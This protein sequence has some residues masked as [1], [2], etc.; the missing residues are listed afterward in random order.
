M[1]NKSFTLRPWQM[2]DLDSLVKYADNPAIARNLTDAF[3]SPY[4]RE[5]GKKYMEMVCSQSFE[6]IFAIDMDGE[7][8]GSIGVFPQNDIHRLN[9]EMGYWL[10]EPFWGNGIMPEAVTQIVEYAFKTLDISR[11]Y[12]RPFGRNHASQRVLE[13]AGFQLEARFEKVL[14]KNGVLEDELIYGFRKDNNAH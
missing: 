3:P 4:T 7:A 10:A 6:T 12:A 2:S 9:A 14:L 11:V 5:D 8:V 13:K 1:N